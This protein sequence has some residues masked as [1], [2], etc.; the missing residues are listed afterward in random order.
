MKGRRVRYLL[1]C[2]T[3]KNVKGNHSGI[4]KIPDGNMGL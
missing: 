2:T 3:K 4:R 1:T